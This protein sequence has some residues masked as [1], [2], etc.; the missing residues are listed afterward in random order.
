MTYALL[1]PA[2]ARQMTCVISGHVISGSIELESDPD[3]PYV[4]RRIDGRD[5]LPEMS[6]EVVRRLRRKRGVVDR[7][8]VR[9]N[10]EN[11]SSFVT[12]LQATRGP[13]DGFTVHV[14]LDQFFSHQAANRPRHSGMLIVCRAIDDMQKITK[15]A[16][17]GG[18]A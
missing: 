5:D 11:F 16:R 18:P 2:A 1:E 7:R 17:V 10:N 12:I 15:A 3:Q 4:S 13:G 9:D 8:A 6:I 14:L